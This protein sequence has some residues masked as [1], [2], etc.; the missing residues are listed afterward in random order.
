VQHDEAR[1]ERPGRVPRRDIS[2]LLNRNRVERRPVHASRYFRSTV[3][4]SSSLIDR[5]RSTMTP[6]SVRKRASAT[7]A[8]GLPRVAPSPELVDSS[9][10]SV[11]RRSAYRETHSERER[12]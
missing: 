8:T 5:I 2:L 3:K 11:P 10:E 1:R 9:T 4:A 7:I 12:S 6:W